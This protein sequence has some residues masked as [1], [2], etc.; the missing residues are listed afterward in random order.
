MTKWTR[1]NSKKAPKKISGVWRIG[2]NGQKEKV[3]KQVHNQG[4]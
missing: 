1:K 4:D 2:P 3:V